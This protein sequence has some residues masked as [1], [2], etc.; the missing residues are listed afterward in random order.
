MDD[1]IKLEAPA[2]KF[3]SCCHMS[4]CIPCTWCKEEEKLTQTENG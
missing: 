2:Y 1:K 3:K 4:N